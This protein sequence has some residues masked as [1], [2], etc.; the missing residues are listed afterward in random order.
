MKIFSEPY[1]KRDKQFKSIFLKKITSLTKYHYK[2]CYEYQKIL[3]SFKFNLKKDYRLENL[4]FISIRLFKNYKLK[5]KK[6]K[7][8]KK[9]LMSSGTSGKVS[10]IFLDSINVKNQIISLS[11]IVSAYLGK[12]RLPML[13]VDSQ[14]IFKNPKSYSAR[15]AA[16]LGFSIF[17]N[18]HTYLLDKDF[19]IDLKKLKNFL[20]KYKKEKFLVFGFTSIIW[21]KLILGLK[22]DKNI[23]NFK[24]AI[25]IHG[26]GWKKLENKKISNKDFKFKLNQKLN[27]KKIH[28]YYGM[29]EQAGSIFFECDKCEFFLTSSYSEILI[30]DN[31]FKIVKD[32][33]IGIVQLIS[34]LPSSYPGHNLITEDLGYISNNKDC[35]CSNY[36]KRFKILGRIKEAELRGCS[37]V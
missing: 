2:N 18:D 30:R 20:K 21:N 7:E 34:S 33:N 10:K 5:S 16:I 11:K 22:Q 13:I 15:A 19:N 17:G 14:D 24:N 6:E 25:L 35:N 37:D 8:I 31:N 23:Y 36:G 9:V 27:I 4:P 26:G 3:K 12:K 32:G 1:L 28:N 29:I